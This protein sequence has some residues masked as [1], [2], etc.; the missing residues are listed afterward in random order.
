MGKYSCGAIDR[1]VRFS[2]E[3]SAI[4]TKVGT[5]FAFERMSGLAFVGAK[6]KNR[7]AKTKK[8]DTIKM[9]GKKL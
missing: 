5:I 8:M 6:V 2:V 1:P 4:K 7:R 9:L 3:V